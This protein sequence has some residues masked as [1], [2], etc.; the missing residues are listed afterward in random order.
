M[1]RPLN[2]RELLVAGLIMLFALWIVRELCAAP[3]FALPSRLPYTFHAELLRPPADGDGCWVRDARG[4]RWCLRYQGID[5][6]E[7]AHKRGRRG[8]PQQPYAV[9]AREKNK[10]LLSRGPLVVTIE[11]AAA[12]YRYAARVVNADGVDVS[13]ALVERGLAW[14]DPRYLEDE[15]LRL[16][17]H[18]ARADRRG[19]WA[20][21]T[22][23]FPGRWRAQTDA[24]SRKVSPSRADD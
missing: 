24:E 4:R 3:P 22:S 15:S 20:D 6:P 12:W 17:E 2:L 10:E 21:P 18:A 9:E 16:F 19:L 8:W 14:T 1:K 5:C 11:G 13:R 23:V 7:M